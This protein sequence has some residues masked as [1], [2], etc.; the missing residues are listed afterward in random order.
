MTKYVAFLR[1][2][3]VG[4]RV[5]K[6]AELRACLEKAALNEVRT[7]IAS[8]NVIF[9]SDIKDKAKLTKLIE[10]SI[11]KTFGMKVSVLVLDFTTLEKLVKAIPTTWVN[12][13]Q[14]KCDVMLLWDEVDNKKILDQMPHNLEIEDIKYVPGAVIWRINR[15]KVGKSRMFKLVGTNLHKQMTSR[16][17]N[18][19]RKIYALIK[20]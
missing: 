17:P 4:G 10:E 20:D 14:M 8:G 13:K 16:N 1:A 6:M 7:F 11:E 2:V 19:I 15:D 9:S 12:D 5:I 18:T 3:N